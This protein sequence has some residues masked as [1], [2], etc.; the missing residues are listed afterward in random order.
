L[1]VL[2]EGGVSLSSTTQGNNPVVVHLSILVADIDVSQLLLLHGAVAH[3]LIQRLEFRIE[4]LLA[5]LVGAKEGFHAAS[6][7]SPLRGLHI[8][9]QL[10]QMPGL[11]EN[12]IG[13]IHRL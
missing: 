10:E 9:Q 1:Q 3:H 12:L 5:L 2:S 6:D 11:V 13:M 4:S 7:V 8:N